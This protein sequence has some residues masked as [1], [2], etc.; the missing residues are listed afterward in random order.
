MRFF[1]GLTFEILSHVYYW[2]RSVRFLPYSTT[3]GRG[4]GGC[5]PKLWSFCPLCIDKFLGFVVNEYLWFLG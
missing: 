5:R 1:L 3:E 2:I 4:S